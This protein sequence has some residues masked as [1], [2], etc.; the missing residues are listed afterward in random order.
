ME[1]LKYLKEKWRMI[2]NLESG[3]VKGCTSS[4]CAICPLSIDNNK[5]SKMCPEFER[6]EPEKVI[7]L[8]EKW[9]TENPQKT[10][11]QDFLERFPNVT[12]SSK[13]IPNYCAL[14]FG[15]LDKCE[16]NC[17]DCWNSPLVEGRIIWKKFGY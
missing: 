7:A 6:T 10:I 17:S 1:A 3:S 12:L 11:L 2:E 9:S 16:E 8:V 13:G 4:K 14:H 5:T 15:Y